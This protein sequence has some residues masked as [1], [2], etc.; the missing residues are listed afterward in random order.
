MVGCSDETPQ[1][2]QVQSEQVKTDEIAQSDNEI[3]EKAKQHFLGDNEPVVKDAM[4]AK[5]NL[6]KVGVVD[7]GTSRDGFAE[8]VCEVLRTDFDIKDSPLMVEVID[9]QQLVNNNKWIEL[10]GAVC[11]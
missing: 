7:D 1:T 4:W 8:Y 5:P 2:E 3:R 9:I 6:F 10:G 11:Q